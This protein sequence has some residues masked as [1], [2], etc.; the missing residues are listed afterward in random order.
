MLADGFDIHHL[1]GNHANNSPDN[2]A[3]MESDDHMRLHGVG[4]R[5]LLGERKR[6][7]TEKRIDLDRKA[8]EK[9]LAGHMWKEVAGEVLGTKAKA[10]AAAVRARRYAKEFNA[11]WPLAVAA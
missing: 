3:L 11:P 7:V 4:A 10:E 6:V 1:D 2:L 9:R 5:R 8:Y